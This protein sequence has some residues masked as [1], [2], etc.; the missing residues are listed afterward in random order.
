[1][2]LS[3]LVPWVINIFQT[4]SVVYCRR[5]NFFLANYSFLTVISYLTEIR[6]SVSIL[7]IVVVASGLLFR[8]DVG[9][10][11]FNFASRSRLKQVAKG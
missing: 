2:S 1:M 9:S 11:Y 10:P 8:N 7:F 4:F 5:C 6:E 3:R